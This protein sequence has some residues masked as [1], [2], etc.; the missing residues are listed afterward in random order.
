MGGTAPDGAISSGLLVRTF[1]D[2]K[3]GPRGG[4][5]IVVV[6][7]DAEVQTSGLVGGLVTG[8]HQ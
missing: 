3:R 4:T 7:N 6:V 1:W 8:A 2:P 5:K